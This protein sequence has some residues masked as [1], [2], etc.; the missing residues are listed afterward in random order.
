MIRA[1]ERAE[2]E[3]AKAEALEARA[4]YDERLAECI[5]VAVGDGPPAGSG[6]TPANW[7]EWKLF[8]HITCPARAG[9]RSKTCGNA[10]CAIGTRCWRMGD[11]GLTG[12]G[13][14][15]KRRR[16]V[17]LRSANAGRWLLSDAGGA[18]QGALSA[19]RRALDRS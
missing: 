6:V 17:S 15:I 14:P 12:D 1:L 16:R 3:A 7:R 13:K 8:G 4:V 11:L 5:A 19:T 9:K 10:D 18:W 2:R